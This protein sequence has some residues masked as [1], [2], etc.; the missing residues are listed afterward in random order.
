L[1]GPSHEEL[2]VSIFG[3]GVGECIVLHVGSGQWIIVDSCLDPDTRAP[4]ALTYLA[5]IGVALDQVVAVVATHWHDDHTRGIADVVQACRK[6]TFF[7]SAALGK[8][9]FF[10]LVAA[11]PRLQLKAGAGSGVDEMRRVLLYLK[12][13]KRGIQF[14]AANQILHRSNTPVNCVVEA[15]SPS[16][17]TQLRALLAFAPKQF[18][19][20]GSVPNPGP[21]ESSVALHVTFGKLGVLL[22]AD[23]EVGTSD[24]MGWRATVA[25]PRNA[26]HLPAGIV[27]VAHHGSEGAD[28]APAWSKFV[29]PSAHLALT[30][31]NSS[32]LPRPGDIRRLKGRSPFVFHASPAPRKKLQFDKATERTL[33][34]IKILKRL[35]RMGRIRFRG[36]ADG[37]IKWDLDGAAQQL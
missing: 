13:S 14:S 27:K 2:E 1:S 37:E 9:E 26:A 6:A 10:S 32:R 24:A 22:G 12:E 31:F 34:G 19:A 35:T 25:N 8:K 15:L 4:V 21:N 16:S 3:P 18:K 29:A 11:A 36:S 20:M 33:G 23:L 17:G 30:P 7:C 28:H 5:T